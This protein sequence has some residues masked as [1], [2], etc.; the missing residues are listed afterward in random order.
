MKKYLQYIL[1]RLFLTIVFL[2]CPIYN[3]SIFC[4]QDD[5]ICGTSGASPSNNQTGGLY[6]TAK[7]T[8]KILVVF[9][10][11]KDD[12]DPHNFWPVGGNPTGWDTYI[13]PT[14]Q[15]G[16]SNLIN[17]TNYY[18]TMSSGKFHVIGEAVSGIGFL[19]AI[20]YAATKH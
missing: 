15:T 14:T 16:S 19:A 7:G 11:F 1:P 13:D 3:Q 5:F 2:N 6:L 4:A 18:N 8:L 9:A 10:R 20:W 17:L 12:T